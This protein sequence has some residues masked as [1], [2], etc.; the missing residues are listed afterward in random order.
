M[1]ITFFLIILIISFSIHIRFLIRFVIDK[2]KKYLYSYL[3]TAISNIAIAVVLSIV[4]MMR[5][6]ILK[7]FDAKTT[8]WVL[9][10]VILVVILFV[11]IG[12]LKTIY[13]RCQLPEHYHYNF[14]GKKVL[15]LSVVK[16]YEVIT[17]FVTIPI[18]LLIGA[19]F[20]ARLINMFLYGHL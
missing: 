16:P 14:F 5:P 3:A 2:K 4:V 8:M 11:K 1:L 13:K 10:G 7:K 20:I 17:F 12:I 15:H 6:E 19:Y 9:S 18:F